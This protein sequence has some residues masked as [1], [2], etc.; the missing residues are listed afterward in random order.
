[1]LK[2]FKHAQGATEADAVNIVKWAF[3]AA[4][5]GDKT[6]LR[7]SQA[8][9]SEGVTSFVKINLSPQLTGTV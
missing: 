9:L 5:E 6:A 2:T 3:K 7:V 8:K 1:M 4:M